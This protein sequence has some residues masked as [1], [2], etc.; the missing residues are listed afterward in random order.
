MIE[1]R[2]GRFTTRLIEALNGQ[3]DA[4]GDSVVTLDETIAYVSRTVA[5]ESQAEGMS[6]H[7]TA[8]P[9]YLLDHLRLPLS[10]VKR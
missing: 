3:A 1:S 6:Q 5:E 10:A 8:S 9:P 2:L 4:D 7:P